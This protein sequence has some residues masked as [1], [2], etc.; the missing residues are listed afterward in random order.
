MNVNFSSNTFINLRPDFSKLN[1]M[2]SNQKVDFEL[3][4]A[5]RSDL[6]SYRKDNGAVARILM[7]NNDWDN[8]RSGGFSAISNLSQSQIN[9]LRKTNTH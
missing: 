8:Y 9:A 5:S 7:A 3:L 2:D 6:D 1:L 4:M